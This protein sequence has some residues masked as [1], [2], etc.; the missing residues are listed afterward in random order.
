MLTTEVAQFRR[1]PGDNTVHNVPRLRFPTRRKDEMNNM[2]RHR[3]CAGTGAQWFGSLALLAAITG[4]P[5]A[6]A[7]NSVALGATVTMTSTNKCTVTVSPS[8]ATLMGAAW[9][10]GENPP[11]Q[12]APS[13]DMTLTTGNEPPT[14]TVA[15]S[16]PDACTVNN[17]IVRTSLGNGV[18]PAPMTAG[19][20]IAFRKNFGSQGGF[21]RFMPYL[22]NATFY[23]ARTPS[24]ATEATGTITWHSPSQG[25]TPTFEKT[26]QK[27]AGDRVDLQE[28]MGGEAMFLTDEYVSD[29]GA[30]LIDGGNNQGTFSTSAP[31]ELYK[32]ARLSFGALLSTDPEN[33][34]GVRDPMLAVDGD[35]ASMTWTVYIDQV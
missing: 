3:G 10:Y 31:D 6:M 9:R 35:T 27:H 7:S 32:S 11:V 29:G 17:M 23:T 15:A 22:A 18:T 12:G 1:D 26:P 21:W 4:A 5:A 34:N 16:G 28:S 14:V 19:Q 24:E 8:T 20:Q 30:L 33:V 13:T 2:R 25:Y